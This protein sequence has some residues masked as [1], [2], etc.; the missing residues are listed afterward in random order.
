MG[1]WII[2]VAFF[3]FAAGYGSF[4]SHSPRMGLRYCSWALTLCVVAG[5]VLSW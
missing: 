1:I 5:W 3:M 4:R 2:I